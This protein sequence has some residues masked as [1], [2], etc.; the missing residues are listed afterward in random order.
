MSPLDLDLKERGKDFLHLAI[1]REKKKARILKKQY[2]YCV[3]QS[4]LGVNV[5]RVCAS[6]CKDLGVCAEWI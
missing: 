2:A 4:A 3:I 6:V 5:L 1:G